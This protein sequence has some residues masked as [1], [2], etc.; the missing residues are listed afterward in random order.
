MTYIARFLTPAGPTFGLIV[1]DTAY[2]LSGGDP[3]TAP[4]QAG[5]LLGAVDT[6]QL[7]PP[8]QP[9]KIV[10]VGRN[11]AAHAA[12]HSA[13]VPDDPMLFLKPPSAL[14]GHGDPVVIPQGIGRVEHEAEL[15]VIIGQRAW[16]VERPEALDYVLGYTCA[17]DVSARDFQ[18]KDGQWGRAKGFDTFCPLGPW[19][20][21]DLDPRD[22]KVSCRVNGEPR[23]SARTAEM[24]F[25]VPALIA[26]ISRV[27]TL[28]PGDVILT[29]TPAGVGPLAEGDMVEVEIEGI[30]VL[31]NPVQSGPAWAW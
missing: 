23:Q 21:T 22:L 13:P 26:F 30:G 24:V 1:E 10:C 31:R 3:F 28:L 12:E 18:K 11:Y 14:I 9:S 20:V 5:D 17:N 16:R 29:G 15:A 27:M 8:V 7:L 6:L 25:D 4:P 19:I 2:A